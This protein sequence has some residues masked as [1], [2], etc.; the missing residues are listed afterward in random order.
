ME[1]QNIKFT[2]FN[3]GR[4][5]DEERNFLIEA[6]RKL[7]VKMY[8]LDVV[9]SFLKVTKE[10]SN[11]IANI[12]SKVRKMAKNY[13]RAQEALNEVFENPNLELLL[14]Y[15]DNNLIGGGRLNRI[16]STDAS[17]LDI[18]IETGDTLFDRNIWKCAVS[19]VEGYFIDNGFKKMYLEIPF[20]EGPLLYRA[21]DL[22][23][24]EN[25]ND[26][27]VLEESVTYVLFKDLGR[28]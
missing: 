18:V 10:D 24:R 4:L 2:I 19:F 17:L 6:Y 13:E 22:G 3:N 28:Q 5:S 21:D 23:F 14:I 27:K 1:L 20:Q 26:I 9:D 7:F 25:P 8:G 15:S 12:N 11:D 16:N